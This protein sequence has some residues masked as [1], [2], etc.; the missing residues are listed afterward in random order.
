MDKI[1]NGKKIAADIL[2]ELKKKIEKASEEITLAVVLVGDNAASKTYI[3]MKKKTCE[4]L[5]IKSYSYELPEN[6]EEKKLLNLIKELNENPKIHGIL[7]QMPLPIHI[8][9]KK[10]IYAISPKKDIDGFHPVN[11]GK[12]VIGDTNCFI[13]CTPLGIK[14]LLQK[15]Q[16]ETEKKH[17][18]IVGRSNLVGRP[19]ANLLVQNQKGANATVTIAHRHTQ[20]LSKITVQADILI[21]AAG[22]PHL[23]TKEMVRDGAVIIDVGINKINGKIV[24]DV[25]FENVFSKVSKITP[26]PGG[27]GPMTIAMLMQNT[28]L[29]YIQKK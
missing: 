14:T 25:D 24:G 13:P 26:V 3:K 21:A 22:H 15:A 27:V 9:A 28:Y 23:I 19:L 29:S 11:V 1:I 8:D 5:G 10:I 6:T 16:V 18:V 12:M 4:K 17:V 20:N 2:N 7:V